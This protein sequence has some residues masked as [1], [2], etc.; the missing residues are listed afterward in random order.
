M[1]ISIRKHEREL[2]DFLRTEYGAQD[3]TLQG[4]GKHNKLKFRC[5]GSEYSYVVGDPGDFRAIKNIHADLKRQLGEPHSYHKKAHSLEEVTEMVTSTTPPPTPPREES[6]LEKLPKLRKMV[7]VTST[8][9]NPDLVQTVDI[10][11]GLDGPPAAPAAQTWTV[12]VSAYTGQSSGAMVWFIF[13]RE[14]TDYIK[15]R[16]PEPMLIERLDD[17]HW[18]ITSG[19]THSFTP[20]QGNRMRLIYSDKDVVPFGSSIA[21]VV[22]ANGEILIFLAKENRKPLGPPFYIPKPKPVPPIRLK[23]DPAPPVNPPPPV[24]YATVTMQQPML[25]T[26][27]TLME[28]RMLDI[29]RQIYDIQE[30]CPYRLVILPDGRLT[31]RA[32]EIG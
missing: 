12:K 19:G 11:D 14:A 2:I 24:Q 18:Q 32:P 6:M 16:Y 5:Q 27:S 10:A 20:Y 13:P 9:R 7:P 1:P 29:I 21:D 30:L 28:Q 25:M 4:G 8:P 23:I 15:K 17:E 22:E 3:C 31:W 26:T